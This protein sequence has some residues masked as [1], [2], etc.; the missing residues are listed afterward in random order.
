[1]REIL[2]PDHEPVNY[3]DYEHR[4]KKQEMIMKEYNKLLKEGVIKISGTKS[5]QVIIWCE[6]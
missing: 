6:K 4:K 1:M 2:Y 5:K 3:F